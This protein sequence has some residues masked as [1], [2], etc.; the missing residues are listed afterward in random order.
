MSGSNAARIPRGRETR[1][2]PFCACVAGMLLAV[3]CP[4]ASSA[5]TQ[6]GLLMSGVQPASAPIVWP[7]HGW[8]T[9]TPET[10]GIDSNALV[11]AMNTIRARHLP[12]RSLLIERHGTIVLDAY[13]Y[14]FA[15][16]QTHEAASVTKSVVATLVGIAAG[17]HARADLDAP[18]SSYLAL[19][20]ADRDDPRKAR[21]TLADALSMTSGL[22]C[23]AR[24]GRSPEQ[25]MEQSPHWA[26]NVL[27]RRETAEPGRKFAYC[28][29]SMQI[30]SAVLTKMTGMSAADYAR[31]TLFAPLGI[32]PPVWATP[33]NADGVSS[34]FTGL[35]LQP[36]DMAKLGYL[37][38]HDG[39]WDGTQIVPAS[40]V[41][42]A[43]APHAYVSPT[44]RYGYGMWL[45][46]GRGHMGGPPDF[47]ANG[48]GGQRIAVVP[49]QD[50]VV[51]ITGH[52]LDANNVSALIADVV[53]SD[54][55]M[56]ADPA[57]DARLKM[58]VADASFHSP[59]HVAAAELQ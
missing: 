38:L 48:V 3:T 47:E 30:V 25:Q 59:S 24:N 19:N 50:M 31:N 29:G 16:N 55:A 36:R 49:S 8:A 1:V 58:S 57:G 51:V 54:Q 32:E 39:M 44:V 20:D 46:P 18:V 35:W 6:P 17:D 37:W 53:K 27:G 56:P 28:G 52:G 41:T 33:A 5:A 9:D 22:D 13:F 23:S 26:A 45:Y 15:D 2:F 40:Y 34:G 11:S 42:A 10:Q 21:I 4:A 12:V 14:P 43:L 7:T